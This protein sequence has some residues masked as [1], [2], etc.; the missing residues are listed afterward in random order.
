M[1]GISLGDLVLPSQL[2]E[3]GWPETSSSSSLLKDVSD[4]EF[5]KVMLLAVQD[6]VLAKG[7]AAADGSQ[8][9]DVDGDD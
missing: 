1:I 4:A 5:L 3:T 6:S 7:T 8:G 2:A 9:G